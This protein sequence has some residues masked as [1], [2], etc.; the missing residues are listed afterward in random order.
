MKIIL[1]SHNKLVKTIL[2]EVISGNYWVVD[3]MNKNLINVEAE[4]NSWILKSNTE[5]KISNTLDN[6]VLSN[7]N[8][9]DSVQ[10]NI[11]D[12]I[13][14]IN[15]IT[16]EKYILHIMPTYHENV[17][18]IVDFN[19]V[20][21]FVIGNNLVGK[22][23]YKN[24]IDINNKNLSS[25]Q[26]LISLEKEGLKV[27]NLDINNALYIN[28]LLVT[29]SLINSGDILFFSGIYIY[30]FGS[31]FLISDVNNSVNYDSLV[32]S[33]RLLCQNNVNDYTNIVDKHVDVYEKNKYFQRPPR[34]KR[35]ITTKTFDIDPPTQ[36]ENQQEM[37]L[38]FTIAPMLTMGMTSL[39]TG[40]NS[41]NKIMTGEST[42]KNEWTSLLITGCMLLTMVFF[43]LMQKFYVKI[44]KK[45]KEAKRRKKYKKYISTKREEIFAEIEYQKQ[46]LIEDYLPLRNVEAIILNNLRNLWERKLEHKDFLDLRLGVGTRKPDIDIKYPQEHFTMEE[47]DLKDIITELV[48]ESKDIE[49]VPIT[50]NLV[51]N[52]KLGLLGNDELLKRY[53]DGLLLQVVAYHG[54]D[55]LRLVILTEDTKCNYWDKYRNLPFVWNNEK[56]LR[57]YATNQDEINKVTGFLKEEFNYRKSIIG[58]ND[59]IYS[60]FLPYYLIIADDIN[61]VKN[62]ILIKEILES[63]Q[64]YGYSVVMLSDQLDLLPN[65][66]ATFINVDPTSSGVFTNE[67]TQENQL[68]FSPDFVDFDIKRS[69]SKVSNVPLDIAN[70][71]FILPKK[72]SF[73]EMYDVGNVNQLNIL[74]RWKT[75]DVVNTLE[76]PVGIDEAAQAFKIDLHEKAHGPH[77]LIAGMTGSGKSEWIITYILSMAVNYSPEEV[78]FVLIDYKGG[79]LA[80]TFDDQENGIK[81]P[82]VVGT[83][84]NLDIVEIKRSLAS[85]ES[86]LKRRQTMFKKAREALNESS[87]DIYK[88]Q[89]LYRQGKVK[90]PMSHLFIISDEFAELKAQQPEFMDQLISTARIGRSLGVHLILATQK[91]SGVVDDQIWSNSKFRVCLKVQDKS[92][93]NDMLKCPDA[94]MLKDT[95]RFYFQVGYNELFAKGQ[96][97]YAGCP[98]FEA[99]KKV[100]QVDADVEFVS[101]MGNVLKASNIEKNNT[102][103]EFKGEELPNILNHIID[104]S[105]TIDLK[106]T[107]LWL[108][109]IPGVIYVDKLREKYNYIKED[110]ILNPIIGEYDD[111]SRQQQGLL[112][113]PLSQDGNVIIYGSSGSGKEHLLTT[114]LWSIISNHSIQEVNTYILDFGSQILNNFEAAPHVGDIIHSGMDEKIENL[115][116][117]I[118]SEISK[119]RKK[120]VS[121]NGNYSDFIKESDEKIPSILVIINQ[122]EVFADLYENYLDA[123]SEI[124]RD[125][126]RYGI[127]FILTSSSI[128]GIKTKISQNFKTIL[129]LQLNDEMDYRNVIGNTNGLI[130]SKL[131]GRGLIKLDRVVEFQTAYAKNKDTLYDEIKTGCVKL[132]MQYKMKAR[133]IPVLPEIVSF[134]DINSNIDLAHIPVGLIKKSLSPAYINLKNNKAHLIAARF[135]DDA[136]SF[137]DNLIYVLNNTDK[138]NAFIFDTNFIYEE[139][140]YSNIKYVA[141]NFNDNLKIIDNYSSQ[142]DKVLKKN[143]NNKKSIANIK[144]C[145]CV[146]LGIDSFVK[147]L[148]DDNRILFNNIVNSTKEHGK[149]HFIFVDSANNLKKNEFEQW[150]KD[151]VDTSTGLYLGDGFAEQYAIKPSKI[152][153]EYYDPIGL[154]YGYL[155]NNGVVDFVKIIGKK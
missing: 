50:V 105:K 101:G 97:A 81:L 74:N 12:K 104:V 107:P 142:I 9:L 120:F 126:A 27:T 85:I 102:Q 68:V 96:S 17:N 46:V 51:E 32:F 130:P 61:L 112:T 21:K 155:V 18:L 148:D 78:Q 93:S 4:N 113:L 82:H 23:K 134:N 59:V 39:I 57:Y 129:T 53:L 19:R 47:D 100:E 118:N 115:F 7:V 16:Q 28:N 24:D 132:F 111:P 64:N 152:L 56:T 60:S 33:K 84:T 91:P 108:T 125:S 10:L 95:G 77:G 138:F 69:I 6:S 36:K 2:P 5:I 30:V 147:N 140:N 109:R 14:L 143:N 26:V 70:G 128:T 65:E 54:Y 116:K 146:I 44:Q 31:L 121:F 150:Y 151:L 49:N 48:N 75:S 136:I 88:Y 86:E 67:M 89:S 13:F 45:R 103:Y 80:L 131:V 62:N 114:I 145:V 99:D 3:A 55:M 29:E 58:N 98:Y 94:A 149:I 37:P 20:K 43:P 90:E 52:N 153:Q 79:G 124:T 83:I 40:V 42:L 11:G 110:Y 66:C 34:F 144:E 127:Y 122:F 139:F 154:N 73:L 76:A 63:K 106:I 141:E 123:I 117:F 1:E 25:N 15:S 8:A 35:S 72:Y 133:P 92:D 87:M 22:A 38:I 71:K 135:F 137:I 41:L 119:R